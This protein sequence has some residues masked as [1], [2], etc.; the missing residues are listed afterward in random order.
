VSDRRYLS[1]TLM[2]RLRQAPAEL[3]PRQAPADDWPAEAAY[4]DPCRRSSFST[5]LR[6][7]IRGSTR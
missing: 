1:E 6:G 3:P 4:D 5:T 2:A 7:V